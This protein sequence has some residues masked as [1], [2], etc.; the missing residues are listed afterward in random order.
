LVLLVILPFSRPFL[1]SVYFFSSI[2]LV[3][4]LHVSVKGY[5]YDSIW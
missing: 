1:N 2:F 5:N 3:L 4:F